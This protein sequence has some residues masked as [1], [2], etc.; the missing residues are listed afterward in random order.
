MDDKLGF[1]ANKLL[2][3]KNEVMCVIIALGESIHQI[4]L[5]DTII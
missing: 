1:K 3:D 5:N 2:G 4:L